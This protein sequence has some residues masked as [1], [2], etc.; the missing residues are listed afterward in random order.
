MLCR[1][2]EWREMPDEQRL[3]IDEFGFKV[4]LIW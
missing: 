3:A 1:Q 4:R 2:D